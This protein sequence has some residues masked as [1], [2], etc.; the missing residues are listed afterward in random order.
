MKTN[1]SNHDNRPSPESTPPA[2]RPRNGHSPAQSAAMGQYDSVSGDELT[3]TKFDTSQWIV[4]NLIPSGLSVLTGP[5][6]IGK[7]LF[8]LDLG[9]CVATGIPFLGEYETR[10]GTV[11]HITPED[12]MPR[13]CYRLKTMNKGGNDLKG[14][15]CVTNVPR[16]DQGGCEIVNTLLGR[17]PAARL[18]V[19]D[20]YSYVRPSKPNANAEFGVLIRL[21]KLARE[22][23]AAVVIV[24]SA[25]GSDELLGVPDILYHISDHK[26]K[27]G[28]K[29]LLRK[30]S[31]L[32]NIW[33]SISFDPKRFA[34]SIDSTGIDTWDS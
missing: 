18:V 26:T 27:F 23:K 8:A 7:S 6:K 32:E 34:W 25:Q 30:G 10:R 13:V 16:L 17:N 4:T 33:L 15:Q 9:F 31:D 2:N 29:E 5:H 21:R 1:Y 22:K 28:V 20:S 11:I 3:R 12:A 14:F 24:D 19:I